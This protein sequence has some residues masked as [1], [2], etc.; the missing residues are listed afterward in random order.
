MKLI[1]NESTK[2]ST[3]LL[4]NKHILGIIAQKSTP[5]MM[6][7]IF[8]RI[9]GVIIFFFIVLGLYLPII[10]LKAYT[11]FNNIVDYAPAATHGI[12]KLD[13]LSNFIDDIYFEYNLFFNRQKS[14]GYEWDAYAYKEIISHLD[15]DFEPAGLPLEILEYKKYY[16]V[17]Y[18]YLFFF[19][20][21][22][23]L[24]HILL[25]LF[26]I[27]SVTQKL[28][29]KVF[30]LN[31]KTS[32]FFLGL[33][34]LVFGCI[35]YFV[36]SKSWHLFK[37]DFFFNSLASYFRHGF[38]TYFEMF[39]ARYMNTFNP[40]Y[41]HRFDSYINNAFIY[42]TVFEQ[43]LLTDL[44]CNIIGPNPDKPKPKHNTFESLLFQGKVIACVHY[45]YEL[46]RYNALQKLKIFGDSLVNDLF[47]NPYSCDNIAKFSVDNYITPL[48]VQTFGTRENLDLDTVVKASNDFISFQMTADTINGAV[49]TAFEF[50]KNWYLEALRRGIHNIRGYL[51]FEWFF[52]N[53]RLN[54]PHVIHMGDYVLPPVLFI[55][56]AGFDPAHPLVWFFKKIGVKVDE[57]IPVNPDIPINSRRRR[58]IDGHNFIKCAKEITKISARMDLSLV[59]QGSL[60]W[61]LGFMFM[62]AINLTNYERFGNAHQMEFMWQTMRDFDYATSDF[63]V[64]NELDELYQDVRIVADDLLYTISPENI[65]EK[66]AKYFFQK[67][68]IESLENKKLED[69]K[70]KSH[71]F[72]YTNMFDT[73]SW[74]EPLDNKHLCHPELG[75]T[76]LAFDFS[77][78]KGLMWAIMQNFTHSGSMQ[79]V[80]YSNH[81]ILI[82]RGNHNTSP[83]T[84][85]YTRDL[86]LI[87]FENTNPV[88][89]YLIYLYGY[90][91]PLQTETVYLN[92]VLLQK[93]RHAMHLKCGFYHLYL[94]WPEAATGYVQKLW[95]RIFHKIHMIYFSHIWGD[96]WDHNIL[97]IS[98]YTEREH[99]ENCGYYLGTP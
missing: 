50:A 44:D 96:N 78:H 95:Y 80:G 56:K 41:R 81:A 57:M 67:S 36:L 11:F 85:Q 32:K 76:D 52:P 53:D 93:V 3:N 87:A 4:I 92:R 1:F 55:E 72:F 28:G 77:N 60:P 15:P 25:C 82:Y 84:E 9:A 30:N 14:W 42:V 63:Y 29:Q 74:I 23:V 18:F 12:F 2:Q 49:P 35:L 24:Y 22:S 59:L 94:L 10:T 47:L 91:D 31:V 64:D 88:W 66:K 7:S 99:K 17:V 58:W 90:F 69:L 33:I 40:E 89:M 37:E 79:D 51:D 65:K 16:L 86:F 70:V 34:I 19:F 5:A 46:M 13:E 83:N 43:Y 38:G 62:P 61:Q 68:E 97:N 39:T 26:P 73:L 45:E 20:L 54:H 8:F 75:V 27:F 48:E 6:K 71:L 98:I 21:T